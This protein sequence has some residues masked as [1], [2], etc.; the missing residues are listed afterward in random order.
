M[1][2]NTSINACALTIP[3]LCGKLQTSYASTLESHFCRLMRTTGQRNR[4]GGLL[5]LDEQEMLHVPSY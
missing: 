3:Q 4:A 5:Q 2:G 1:D